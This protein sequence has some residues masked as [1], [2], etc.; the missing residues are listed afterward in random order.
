MKKQK[1]Q[2]IRQLEI[3]YGIPCP[4]KS[5]ISCDSNGKKKS[6]KDIR[7]FTKMFDFV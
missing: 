6:V 1:N 4:F 2:L 3:K 7:Q 5:D